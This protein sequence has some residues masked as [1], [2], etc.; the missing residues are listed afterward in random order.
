M[1]VVATI[2]TAGWAEGLLLDRFAHARV[3]EGAGREWVKASLSEVLFA[4]GKAL[5][6]AR[7]EW[8]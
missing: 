6:G 2:P 5:E 8:P 4:V 3:H 7:A 1:K